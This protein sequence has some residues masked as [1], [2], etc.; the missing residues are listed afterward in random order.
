ML[1]FYDT[2]MFA[3]S[4]FTV[5]YTTGLLNSLFWWVRGWTRVSTSNFKGNPHFLVTESHRSEMHWSLSGIN[6]LWEVYWS[7]LWLRITAGWI[8]KAN[9]HVREC[10]SLHWSSTTHQGSVNFH[11]RRREVLPS[12]SKRHF[13]LS[14]FQSV[15]TTRKI[16]CLVAQT[17]DLV[18]VGILTSQGCNQSG[19]PWHVISLHPGHIS[20]GVPV[21]ESLVVAQTFLNIFIKAQG[22]YLVKDFKT[23]GWVHSTKKQW[24]SHLTLYILEHFSGGALQ[25]DLGHLL[26][27]GS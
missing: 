27:D 9:L 8:F 21:G 6:A 22:N 16:D 3:S 24:W 10:G 26:H 19:H 25:G 23:L 15:T 5:H 18:C 20:R 2:N 17:T 12:I 13:L 7:L 4:Y 1:S 14:F 11:K